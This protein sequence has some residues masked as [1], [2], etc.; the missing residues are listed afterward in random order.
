LGK[1]ERRIPVLKPNWP[2][3]R[4]RI[5]VPNPP[6]I[7]HPKAS[8][9]M[10]P[11]IKPLSVVKPFGQK[12]WGEKIDLDDNGLTHMNPDQICR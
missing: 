10:K 12:R 1:P 11:R 8:L 3:R 2:P 5:C 7:P 4:I 9:A 6:N